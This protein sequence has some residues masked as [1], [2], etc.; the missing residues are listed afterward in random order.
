MLKG[1]IQDRAHAL[2]DGLVLQMDAVDSAE[3][4]VVTL[5][6]AVDVLIVACVSGK[7]PAA[8]PVGCVGQKIVAAP[9]TPISAPSLK[10]GVCWVMADTPRFHH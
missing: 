7:P 5:R 8:E 1:M 2:G 9:H 6:G 4:Q 10:A 3:T